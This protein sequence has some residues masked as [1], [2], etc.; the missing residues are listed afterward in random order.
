MASEDKKKVVGLDTVWVFKD[1]IDKVRGEIANN[2][3]LSMKE[4]FDTKFK[5][6]A[7]DIKGDYDSKY[8]ELKKR[9]EYVEQFGTPE[10]VEQIRLELDALIANT[11][12][13]FDALDALNKELEILSG[14]YEGLKNSVF[15]E[16]QINELINAAMIDG[17]TITDDA[18]LAENIYASKLVAFIG[19]FAKISASQ[20]EG[21]EITGHT[22]ASSEFIPGTSDRRWQIGNEGEGWLANKQISWN[23]NGDVTLG[24][25]VTISY[26]S[27]SGLQEEIGDL[28]DK[29]QNEGLTI[30]ELIKAWSADDKL[31]P[32]E[33]KELL[34]L[35]DQILAEYDRVINSIEDINNQLNDVELSFDSESDVSDDTQQAI[36]AI[37]AKI[38]NFRSLLNTTA[39]T[40]VKDKAIE[41]I[42]YYKN[43]L[44][45][46]NTDSYKCVQI[47]DEYPLE[48]IN[49]Y[50]LEL[51]YLLENYDKVQNFLAELTGNI[52]D[53][54]INN[55]NRTL[56]NL[57]EDYNNLK[58]VTEET[59]E[60]TQAIIDSFSN[61][62]VVS[63]DE[64]LTLKLKLD[65]I[66]TEYASI[67]TS[68]H[69]LIAAY[70]EANTPK[71][72]DNG[73]EHE[74][75]FIAEDVAE[76]L[77]KLTTTFEAYQTNY[78]NAYKILSYYTNEA[79]ERDDFGNIAI[80][81]E[82][83]L[84]DLPL[85]YDVRQELLD[86]YYEAN[87]YYTTYN[88]FG[89]KT[90]WIGK[91]GIY[92]G[93]I[94]A[95]NLRGWCIEGLT[96]QSGIKSELPTDLEWYKYN[97]KEATDEADAFTKI[98][99]DYRDE[100]GNPVV[101]GPTWQIYKEGT[102]HLAKGGIRWNNDEVIFGDSTKI[103]IT[104]EDGTK[105]VI[106]LGEKFSDMSEKID[107]YISEWQD[108]NIIS[109]TEQ[110]S[111]LT[112]AAEI[113]AE[114]KQITSSISNLIK[115]LT[116]A[117][118]KIEVD[119]TDSVIETYINSLDVTEYLDATNKALAA[120]EYYTKEDPEGTFRSVTGSVE[121]SADYPLSDISDYYVARET[122]VEKYN[123]AADFYTNNINTI[124]S[125][126]IKDVKL[127]AETIKDYIDTWASDKLISPAELAEFRV[128]YNTIS[129]EKSDILLKVSKLDAQYETYIAS[130][131]EANTILKTTMQDY[132]DGLNTDAYVAESDDVLATLNYYL[133]Y[134]ASEDDINTYGK[135][136]IPI[137]TEYPL[138]DL[139]EYYDVKDALVEKYN[140]AF[141]AYT[142]YTNS[143][144]VERI[145]DISTINENIDK[146][147]ADWADNNNVDPA[148]QVQMSY[149]A[150]EI[151][152]EAPVLK[153]AASVTLETVLDIEDIIINNDINDDI[154]TNF[155]A[156]YKNALDSTVTTSNINK[157]N[158]KMIA[159]LDVI[160]YYTSSTDGSFIDIIA[161]KPLSAI[162][163]YYNE[164]EAVRKII[165][166]ANSFC[167]SFNSGN[168]G[169]LLGK[170]SDTNEKI[171]SYIDAWLDDNGINPA[172]QTEME[173]IRKEIV[174]ETPTLITA[175]A[176]SIS[177]LAAVEKKI[178]DSEITEDDEL[179]TNIENIK[180]RLDSTVFAD[181]SSDA[182]RVINYYVNSKKDSNGFIA[183]NEKYPLA[184]IDNYYT[185]RENLTQA[186]NEADSLCQAYNDI[187]INNVIGGLSDT[188]TKITEYIATWKDDK[189]ISPAERSELG[190]ILSEILVEEAGVIASVN[191]IT[192]KLN[193]ILT[194][195]GD[196]IGND[197]K[198]EINEIIDTLDTTTFKTAADNAETVLQYYTT[199]AN[200][201]DNGF[202]KII[203]DQK[204][205]VVEIY[206]KER[207]AIKNNYNVALSFYNAYNKSSINILNKDLE[208]Y[209]K[210][211]DEFID[212]VSDDSF[213]DANERRQFQIYRAEIASD[214]KSLDAAASSLRTDLN[215]LAATTGNMYI[216]EINKHLDAI[217]IGILGYAES[218]LDTLDYYIN[219]TPDKNNLVKIDS[220]NS[221]DSINRYYSKAAELN[222]ALNAASSFHART[223]GDYSNKKITVAQEKIA[224]LETDLRTLENLQST[225]TEEVNNWIKAWIDDGTLNSEELKELRLKY[226]DISAE[227]SI[228][229]PAIENTLSWLNAHKND[230]INNEEINVY[231][232][233]L[234]SAHTAY[235]NAFT[236]VKNT[237]D[238]YF[239]DEAIKDP[240]TGCVQISDAYPLD[241]F[242]TYVSARENAVTINN[243][244][245]TFV[246]TYN[247]FGSKL[248]NLSDTG[249][250]TGTLSADKIDGWCLR[251]LTFQSAENAKTKVP[252]NVKWYEYNPE[253][254]AEN[255][256]FTEHT[257]GSGA[258]R[259]QLYKDGSGYVA[260]GQISWQGGD[261][262][263]GDNVTIN[264]AN[265]DG[266]KTALD[267]ES[268]KLNDKI[269]AANNRLT[270]VEGD[271]NVISGLVSKGDEN[272]TALIAMLTAWADNSVLDP[273]EYTEF[274]NKCKQ[275]AAEYGQMK[276]AIDTHNTN[277][278]NWNTAIENETKPDPG[279]AV[280]DLLV[281][282]EDLTN[283]YG[284]VQ[285]A[286]VYYE[287]AE[288]DPDTNC[289][290]ISESHPLTVI[291]DYYVEQNKTGQQYTANASDYI[292]YNRWGTKTTYLGATGIYSG[293]VMGDQIIG[294]TIKGLTIT[295]AAGSSFTID[296]DGT[297]TLG[298]DA[299][300]Y[301]GYDLHISGNNVNIDGNVNINGEAIANG[302]ENATDADKLRIGEIVA[303]YVDAGTV[304]TDVLE[305]KPDKNTDKIH[306][307][308]NY[309]HCINDNGDK[310]LIISSDPLNVTKINKVLGTGFTSN[311][312][313]FALSN[314]TLTN[315][316]T[317]TYP[318][319]NS[320]VWYS[321][322]S[323]RELGYILKGSSVNIFVSLIALNV[324]S[325][326]YIS[327]NLTQRIRA[328]YWQITNG[329]GYILI[330]KK[331]DSG[332]WE[333]YDSIRLTGSWHNAVN[334]WTSTTSGTPYYKTQGTGYNTISI[335]EDGEYGVLLGFETGSI[336]YGSAGL[337]SISGLINAVVD[338]ATPST[339]TEI[340]RDGI[341]TYDGINSFRLTS[342]GVEMRAKTSSTSSKFYGIKVTKNGMYIGN[343]GSSWVLWNPTGTSYDDT[344]LTNTV[345]NLQTRMSTAERE[346]DNLQDTI[347]NWGSSD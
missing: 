38:A 302:I 260:D 47:V 222:G 126:V 1:Y 292:V 336:R 203:E 57:E 83:N 233:K 45:N 188:D 180:K 205:E 142:T 244:A 198:Y 321:H 194:T 256:A 334:P 174:A 201:E 312:S 71:V 136:F 85:F 286:K 241:V 295:D 310:N 267:A 325:N 324:T 278:N 272:S 125:G 220:A 285:S 218:A 123:L 333:E 294:G 170:L 148:E 131:N 166:E 296:T 60:L 74:E 249:I 51:N 323:P 137:N 303:D 342:E 187:A 255:A 152:A 257:G 15:T 195:D 138:E 68:V 34:M 172:E 242:S 261:V 21:G 29:A 177:N 193:D 311:T 293:T 298:E 215:A 290:A 318:Y 82:C 344:E 212:A 151:N 254:D 94:M 266:G 270:A 219:A 78:N 48:I 300:W 140:L 139:Y 314:I 239:G 36:D 65:E 196:K 226:D 230:T 109:Y 102:G 248:T 262:T 114:H 53:L 43:Q 113:R 122:I 281:N 97:G 91:D 315:T 175:A 176:L 23:E 80:I 179:L 26:N 181:A 277:V 173:Y 322:T 143:E 154:L 46:S 327:T 208:D 200:I 157:Y 7:D 149:I 147:I 14:E 259:W 164:R 44:D 159:A 178:N 4:Y 100:N 288:I 316:G 268:E 93:T 189:L 236:A 171:T 326:N 297:F 106:P 64:Q 299:I 28:I 79:T 150:K 217:G 182:Q 27:I 275:V 119:T 116:E 301:D 235:I 9:L 287:S 129:S 238:Y 92:S 304:V 250:Y 247:R 99:A 67:S 135:G 209:A 168:T 317:G 319:A 332:N 240:D 289:R 271:I 153:A 121:I 210:K 128:L 345:G 24:D 338:Q 56:N 206:Y 77:E 3:D 191:D 335:D 86:I 307:E 32:N 35:K 108:D 84:N 227:Y 5:E 258:P 283:A 141:T 279:F 163:D 161:D 105:T 253:A 146:F 61:D 263:L 197:I 280:T 346:I 42:D 228:V 204:L 185:E 216:T 73:E 49:S 190:R 252:D 89:S 54:K 13:K 112:V 72:D 211:M 16:G 192:D 52:A 343:G 95:D 223:V 40:T 273:N 98:T 69:A 103:S 31:S 274:I 284:R 124:L 37:K 246:T 107:G 245:S 58:E 329:G 184:D 243:E 328:D 339:Y 39:Y 20:I 337:R 306:I 269:I 264:W 130:I 127:N 162:D 169:D 120:I 18:I 87:S 96:V 62:N 320:D 75:A 70:E 309:I 104:R 90:T 199:T 207:E 186:I 63:P 8:D 134:N 41:T 22:I 202:I 132:K 330:Y 160:S 59:S 308:D 118:D 305:T 224:Q 221:L 155:T 232:N 145:N 25:R 237:V 6:A 50:Y 10:E 76:Y 156:Q 101:S 158:A 183:F 55:I 341:I 11:N 231:L 111:M 17:V 213:I 234:N 313:N 251:G 167:T 165:N 331:N 144:L 33:I 276:L 133:K 214:S 225:N 19:N 117:Q 12:D 115:N 265:V 347:S 110:R 66:V 88:R 2:T 229:N 81:P 282:Y 340:G 30:K 291:S